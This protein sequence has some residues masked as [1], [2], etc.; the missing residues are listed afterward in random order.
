[1]EPL[2]LSNKIQRERKRIDETL[3]KAGYSSDAYCTA[4]DELKALALLMAIEIAKLDPCYGLTPV[5]DAEVDAFQHALGEG[6]R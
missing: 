2:Q 6:R 4:A 1:M 3:D 5:D